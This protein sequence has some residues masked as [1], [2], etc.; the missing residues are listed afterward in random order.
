MHSSLQRLC[1]L[2]ALPLEE[3]WP[4]GNQAE[5]VT[6]KRVFQSHRGSDDR[7]PGVHRELD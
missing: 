2:I 7:E 1:V 6:S 3:F 5:G 4:I